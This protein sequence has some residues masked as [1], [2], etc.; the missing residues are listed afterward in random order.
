MIDSGRWEQLALRA[1]GDDAGALQDARAIV[2]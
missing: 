2:R 1:Q